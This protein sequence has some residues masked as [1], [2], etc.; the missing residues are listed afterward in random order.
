[1]GV[2]TCPARCVCGIFLMEFQLNERANLTLLEIYLELSNHFYLAMF[3]LHQ[4][5]LKDIFKDQRLE[6]CYQNNEDVDR[7]TCV[8]ANIILINIAIH[9]LFGQNINFYKNKI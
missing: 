6:L 7:K 3:I 9:L 8:F 1:M 2:W 5:N 4:Y